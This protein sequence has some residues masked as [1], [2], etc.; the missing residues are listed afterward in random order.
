MAEYGAEEPTVGLLRDLGVAESVAMDAAPALMRYARELAERNERFGLIA[1]D[2]AADPHRVMAR[3]ILDSVAPHRVV[4]ALMADSRRSRLFDLGSGPGLPGIPLAMVLP[5]VTETV[6]VERRGKR[7]S[8]LL[9]LLPI[10]R[11]LA[12]AVT[13]RVFDGDADR[14]AT[15]SQRTDEAAVVFRAYQQTNESLARSLTRNFGVGAPVCALKGRWEQATMERQLLEEI[16]WASEP[17]VIHLEPGSDGAER[18][19]LTWVTAAPD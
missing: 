6:L 14:I 9:G 10:L 5:E 19:V 17:R 2:D 16:R 11:S 3:H 1:R 18:S 4:A 15:G 13:I 8:F 12:P 7:I